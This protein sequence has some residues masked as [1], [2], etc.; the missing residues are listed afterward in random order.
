MSVKTGE[1]YLGLADCYE[2][3]GELDEKKKVL[4]EKSK[5]SSPYQLPS[6]FIIQYA[7]TYEPSP[8]FMLSGK[9]PYILNPGFSYKAI[10]GL[11]FAITSSSACS[12][13]VFS[14]MSETVSNITF[15]IP[16]PQS[17]L[18]TLVYCSFSEKSQL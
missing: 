11:L 18:H 2:L 6:F 13:P 12:Y 14:A 17:P 1:A 7:S 4:L 9:V 3:Q 16:K 15:P 10:A 8:Y 5:I